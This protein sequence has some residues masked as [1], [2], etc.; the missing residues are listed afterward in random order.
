[1]HTRTKLLASWI[2][3]MSRG[4]VLNMVIK[5]ELMSGD[6]L[7]AEAAAAGRLQPWQCQC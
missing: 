4:I 3:R 7:A 2:V 5:E 6:V 1:M